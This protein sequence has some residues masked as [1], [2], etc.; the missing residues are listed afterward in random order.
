M[1]HIVFIGL[2]ILCFLNIASGIH[3]RHES[4]EQIAVKQGLVEQAI[5]GLDELNYETFVSTLRTYLSKG[6]NKAQ[7][8]FSAKDFRKGLINHLKGGKEWKLTDFKDKGHTKA[9]LK[10]FDQ[11]MWE[12]GI[13][14]NLNLSGKIEAIL[15]NKLHP[16]QKEIGLQN[17]L[18]FAIKQKNADQYFEGEY[19]MIGAPIVTYK[20]VHVIDGHHRWSQLYMLNPNAKIA[21]YNIES[22][23]D[24]PDA[25]PEDVLRRVQLGIGAFF[26]MI[27]ESSGEKTVDVYDNKE[28]SATKTSYISLYLKC[29][30]LKQKNLCDRLVENNVEKSEDRYTEA[31][32]G[33]IKSYA[34]RKGLS[35]SNED[36]LRKDVMNSIEKQIN[37]FILNT[38]EGRDNKPSRILMP[39]TDGPQYLKDTH[40]LTDAEEQILVTEKQK[41][42]NGNDTYKIVKKDEAIKEILSKQRKG[43]I[44]KG[45]PN[46]K[47]YQEYT[48]QSV[49]SHLIKP[50]LLSSEAIPNK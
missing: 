2:I 42:A 12:S 8:K 19:K 5:N 36:Q 10:G 32:I 11:Q 7:L 41:N 35:N 50:D 44:K 31:N 49:L 20:G 21:A 22:I 28:D 14:K 43:E 29:R 16:T 13:A 15:V 27:P 24:K 47:K 37:E 30:F 6:E 23:E 26:G 38:K 46:Y 3:L 39:Q 1:K 4:T 9:Q 25:T 40:I 18:D 33:F 45:D 48:L 17:S 34:L